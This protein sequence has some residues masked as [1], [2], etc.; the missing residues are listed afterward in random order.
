MKIETARKTLKILGAA[1]VISALIALIIGSIA[2]KAPS[3]PMLQTGQND[4]GIFSDG[5]VFILIGVIGLAQGILSFL[6][7]RTG[8]KNLATA[9]A[10]LAILGVLGSA[11]G[12]ITSL[13]SSQTSSIISTALGLASN[14]VTAV[15]GT[16][17]RKGA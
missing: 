10:V 8:K 3:A 5:T 9:A 6:A 17:V 15:S 7:G 2:L 16:I 13:G 4:T 1:A 14:V 12:L 11:Y